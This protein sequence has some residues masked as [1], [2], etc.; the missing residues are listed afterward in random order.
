MNDRTTRRSL[1]MPCKPQ[2]QALLALALLPALL[3]LAPAPALRQTPGPVASAP[4]Q[5][6]DGWDD[7]F[8][9][10]GV[11][12]CA[13][14]DKVF[15]VEVVG[16]DVYVAGE[17][18][19]VG[20]QDGTHGIARWDGRRWH[21]L[22]GGTTR[23]GSSGGSVTADVY[24]IT[25]SGDNLY[26]VGNFDKAGSVNALGIARW[27]IPS[28]TWSAISSGEGPQ[29]DLDYSETITAVAVTGNEVYIGGSFDKIDGVAARR[30]AVWNGSA[31]APLAFGLTDEIAP[32]REGVS[33]MLVVGDL[34][35][36]GGDFDTAI[37]PDGVADIA[38]NNI[39]AWNRT[40]KRWS[41]LAGGVTQD[42]NVFALAH[43]GTNL[44]VGGSFTQ[45]GGK[46]VGGIARWAGGQWSAL[47]SGT[48]GE[49]YSLR[50]ANN[51]LYAAGGFGQAGGVANTLR[52][53]R[54]DGTAW[55]SLRTD[56]L[57]SD[58]PEDFINAVGVLPDGR[59]FIGGDFN[60]GG[61]PLLSNIGIW[62]G[63]RWRG[64]GLGLEDGP[65]FLGADSYAVA[66]N[67]QGQVF[68]GGEFETLGGLPF[69]HIAMWDGNDW[70]DIGG[71][72]GDVS[73][74]LIRGDELYVA[75]GFTRVGN[76]LPASKIARYNMTTKTWSALGTGLPGGYVNTIAFVGEML[77]AGGTEFPSDV[78]CC[79]WKYDGAT[80]APFSQR[81]RTQP[82]FDVGT[83]TNVL[84]LASDGQRLI[85][86]GR[87]L[88]LDERA[89][90]AQVGG[91]DGIN[92]IFV[93]N[94]ADDSVALFGTGADN[95]QYPASV[96][97]IA[98][99]S[100]GI[101]IGGQFKSINGVA[102]INIARVDAN[103]WAALG[104]GAFS[105][106]DDD[107]DDGVSTIV[108]YGGDLYVGGHFETA[109]VEAFNIARWN[110]QA[111]QWS[112]LGC[113]IA[114][115]GETL[116]VEQV[117][118]IAIQP[119]GLP[120]AGLYAAGGIAEAGCAPSMGFAIWNGIGGPLPAPGANRVFVPF[121]QR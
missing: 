12:C 26:A 96:R 46:T 107:L 3:G 118:E 42:S 8:S 23:A 85:V 99:A 6:A 20:S 79:L 9:S 73:A 108:E 114:R 33:T 113:G 16:S 110:K 54:W 94:P 82:F 48:N 84:A 36:V 98:I 19:S 109:G 24:D 32:D 55:S 80:W 4:A 115:N 14:T 29:D 76:N 52:L 116:S 111:Q 112:A 83:R 68:V 119:A 93:Y 2:L 106:P 51:A 45:A 35:Y 11:T 63:T 89:T 28:Q 117:S 22:G 15:D 95:N 100:D 121:T 62:D 30:V 70:Q 104:T 40:T 65:G 53:A 87:F 13:G 47:G 25:V 31:W 44:F 77:Y 81:Y 60:D 10:P 69:R 37:N 7:R 91:Q 39:A 90:G 58:P 34:V 57:F 97:T 50:L 61:E 103:G 5:T 105:A 49:V 102:A 120:N 92:E 78:D 43:D 21:S 1:A 88:D 64:T 27:N 72:D 18:T 86:G 38:A 71:T 56:L 67:A 101:Y 74:L 17:F 75:G 41:G 66:V 59:V